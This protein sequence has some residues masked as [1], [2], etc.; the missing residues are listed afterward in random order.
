[1]G[2]TEELAAF[3]TGVPYDDLPDAVREAAKRR[4]LDAV[5]VG[6]ASADRG[7]ADALRRGVSVQNA[8]GR[9]RLWGTEVS[10]SP[11]DAAMYDA[12]LA[13]GGNDAVFLAPSLAGVGGT[14]AAV[15]AAG[16]ARSATGEAVLSGLSVALEVRGE[17][18]WKAPIDGFHPA[19]H[20]AVAGA[21]GAG[22]AMDLSTTA[23]SNAIG[24]AA[25]RPTVAVDDLAD[26]TAAGHA[27]HTAVY[28]CLLAESGVAGPDPFADTDARATL[29]GPFNL[30]LDPG[31]ERVRDAALLPH[32][33]HPYAQTAVEATLDL[34]DE[35]ALDP[36]DVEAVHVETFADAAPVVDPEVI[37]AALVDRDCAVRS[38]DR[39]DLEPV[40]ET[41]DVVA[42]DD[43]T[44]RAECG[45]VP[46]R[47]AVECRDGTVHEADR[48]WFT[49]HPAAPAS[50]GTVEEK[51][52][53]L[54]GDR[55][56]ADH[57]RTIVD[58]VRSLEAESAAEL[59]RLLE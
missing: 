17:L 50:W 11:P 31:C 49:G 7:D 9:S 24:L 30:D 23:V 15:L 54:V 34:A 42:S 10:A 48:V 41:V 6:V 12:G 19:T 33:A 38:G 4:V 18:A 36:A 57:R 22:R 43:L 59:T 46:A 52:H 37:A 51:F 20:D 3:A 47:V 1:M 55:Y 35:A 58:T 5:G 28:A 21:A 56:D 16:E 45:E 44:E 40:A 27:A 32:D 39:A 2:S 25:T 14:V 13:S 29:G 26:P 8:A 53:A